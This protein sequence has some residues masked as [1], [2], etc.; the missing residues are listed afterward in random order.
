M[1]SALNLF[2]LKSAVGEMKGHWTAIQ[3][4]MRE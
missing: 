2:V 3:A 4:Q 1:G